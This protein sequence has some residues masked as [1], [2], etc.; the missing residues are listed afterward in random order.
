M[1]REIRR[2]PPNWEHPRDVNGNLLPTHN[3]FYGDACDEWVSNFRLWEQGEHPDQKRY[4]NTPKYY[5]EWDN[6]PPDKTYYLPEK[7]TADQA[8]CYQ[9]YETVTEGT[10]TSPIFQ[11]EEEMVQWLLAQGHSERAARG[12]VKDGWAPTLA[13][14]QLG[15]SVG[16][17]MYNDPAFDSKTPESEETAT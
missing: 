12:F 15:T 16:I 11:T 17:D 13:I 2:V 6:P 1:G 5:W 4:P 9:I 8:T 3:R 7:W 14:S 10:P